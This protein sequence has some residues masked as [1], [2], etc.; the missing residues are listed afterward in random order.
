MRHILDRSQSLSYFIPQEKTLTVMLAR[1]GIYYSSKLSLRKSCIV[2]LPPD[3]LTL[4][5]L[6]SHPIQE[7]T[8]SAWVL[9]AETHRYFLANLTKVGYSARLT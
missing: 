5:L 7:N 3:M 4:L 8:L 1:L 6:R 9:V 2:T